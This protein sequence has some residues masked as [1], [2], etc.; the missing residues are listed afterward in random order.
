LVTLRIAPKVTSILAVDTSEGM[1]A[2]LESKVA[3]SGASNVR[4]RRCTLEAL[5][6]S[7]ERFDGLICTQVLAHVPSIEV[8]LRAFRSLLNPK[9]E[10]FVSEMEIVGD[11]RGFPELERDALCAALHLSGFRVSGVFDAASFAIEASNGARSTKR[12]YVIRAGLGAASPGTGQEMNG[13]S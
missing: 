1:L 8:A 12:Y 11:S 2:V 10:L 9:G 3:A 6:D 5:V 7:G 4:P 13:S